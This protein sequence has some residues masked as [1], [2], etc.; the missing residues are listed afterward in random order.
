MR[1]CKDH[2]NAAMI[3]QPRIVYGYTGLYTF[4]FFCVY[5]ASLCPTVTA[6]AGLSK[7]RTLIDL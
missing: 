1:S 2:C 7:Y 5:L 4:I 3:H 6:T